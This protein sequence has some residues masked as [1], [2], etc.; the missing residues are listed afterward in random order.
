MRVIV[1]GGRDFSDYAKLSGSLD[2]LLSGVEVSCIVSGCARGADLLG[3]R[4]AEERGYAVVRY[5][6]DWGLYGRSAGPVRNRVMA[7]NADALVAFW[8]GES[9]GTADMISVARAGGLGVRVVRY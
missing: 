4:Y 6:A 5:P 2:M 8:D 3:E 1:A 9:R 7:A